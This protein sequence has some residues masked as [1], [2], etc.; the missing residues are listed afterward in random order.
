MLDPAPDK[1]D[2]VGGEG[3]VRFWGRHEIA[4]F[5]R[6][7]AAKEFAFGEV[8]GLDDEL[9]GVER[10]EGLILEVEAEFGF[11]GLF[12]RAVTRVT[13]VGEEGL[14]VLIEIDLVGQRCGVTGENRNKH[15]NEP[16]NRNGW[17]FQ[18]A[19]HLTVPFGSRMN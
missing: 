16:G 18:Q 14:D 12:V 13:S 1:A 19:L 10:L 11:A 2:F 15:R 8:A 6:G 7:D 4:R 5:G 17:G 9:A 3:E